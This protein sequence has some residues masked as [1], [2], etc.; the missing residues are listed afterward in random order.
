MSSGGYRFDLPTSTCPR[1]TIG[2]GAVAFAVWAS[3]RRLSPMILLQIPG[4]RRRTTAR[5][6]DRRKEPRYA[7]VVEQARLGWWE[8]EQ[9]RVAVARL[10]NIS[11][12][13]AALTVACDAPVAP[14]WMSVVTPGSKHWILARVAGISEAGDGA[15]CVRLAFVEPCPTEVFEAAVSGT[16]AIPVTRETTPPVVRR[17]EPPTWIRRRRRDTPCRHGAWGGP[18]QPIRP[19]GD[20]RTWSGLFDYLKYF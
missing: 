3:M 9:F 17:S 15:H 16:A 1:R 10:R 5:P 20:K 19:D 12:G 18:V 7:P 11:N 13:G 8:G 14:V 2:E 4:L 6:E